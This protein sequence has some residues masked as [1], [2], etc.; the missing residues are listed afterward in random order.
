MVA[1][2]PYSSANN[3]P[4]ALFVAGKPVFYQLVKKMPG[5][6]LLRFLWQT[7]KATLLLIMPA[8]GKPGCR[9]RRYIP[10]FFLK[11]VWLI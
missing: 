11:K 1:K 3:L 10:D 5:Q 9:A 2:L 8:A 4:C 6:Q 7:G